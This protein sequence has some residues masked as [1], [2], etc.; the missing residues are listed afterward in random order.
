MQ[1]AI[2]GVLVAVAVLVPA[3]AGAT[4]LTRCGSLADLKPL[5]DASTLSTDEQAALATVRSAAEADNREAGRSDA[6]PPTVHNFN[7]LLI[8]LNPGLA[9]G[10]ELGTRSLIAATRI[11][12]V[13]YSFRHPVRSLRYRFWSTISSSIVTSLTFFGATHLE[14][15]L[16]GPVGSDTNHV[17]ASVLGAPADLEAVLCGR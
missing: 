2:C 10:A 6:A 4:I 13:T 9:K 14:I 15:T 7:S 17:S 16:S 5:A 3:S 8:A 1:R 12:G 11:N